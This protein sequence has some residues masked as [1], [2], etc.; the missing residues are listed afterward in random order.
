MQLYIHTEPLKE[1]CDG[2]NMRLKEEIF[3]KAFAFDHKSAAFPRE[4]LCLKTFVNCE[5]MQ[6]FSGERKKF[7]RE[8][9]AYNNIIL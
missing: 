6:I 4:T 8:H 7:V 3:F 9:K 2:K 5:R 1:L